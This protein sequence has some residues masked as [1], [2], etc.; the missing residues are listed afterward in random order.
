MNRPTDQELDVAVA[1]ML[2]FGV[3]VSAIVVLAGGL[4]YL[5]SPWSTAPDYSHFS[6]GDASLRTLA[7]IVQGVAHLHARSLIQAGLVLL[8][9]TPVAR[10]VYCVVG[11]AR[12]R[13]PLYVFVSSLVLLILIYS[14]SKGAS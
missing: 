12:Q 11:F 13:R 10:V 4:L 9:A 6:A 2:R 1:A 14:L 8:I 7:G 3:T 5:Q